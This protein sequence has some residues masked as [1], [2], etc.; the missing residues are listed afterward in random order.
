MTAEF[1][2]YCTIGDMNCTAINYSNETGTF[3]FNV[4]HFTSFRAAAPGNGLDFIGTI[5]PLSVNVDETR[6]NV[7]DLDSFYSDPEGEPLFYAVSGPGASI[8]SIAI[9]G[10]VTISGIGFARGSYEVTFSASDLTN[11]VLANKIVITVTGPDST[12]FP[13]G[14]GGGGGVK[15]EDRIEFENETHVILKDE[16]PERRLLDQLPQPSPT[17]QVVAKPAPVITQ[18]TQVE[19]PSAQT[20]QQTPPSLEQPEAVSYETVDLET[21]TILSGGFSWLIYVG[22]FL[23]LGMFLSLFVMSRRIHHGTVVP[24][25]YPP[26]GPAPPPPAQPTRFD[27]EL[28][29]MKDLSTTNYNSR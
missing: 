23:I 22:L 10:R 19:Q 15:R 29:S 17:G 11:T 4:S 9:D 1:I 26:L 18:N 25:N 8:V 27:K 13:S 5:P 28:E 3:E 21:S 7:L 24:P 6:P 12:S 16:E 20:P 2:R 14:G